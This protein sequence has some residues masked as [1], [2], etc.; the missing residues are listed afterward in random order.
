MPSQPDK[1][2]P[3]GG[4]DNKDSER[5]E[6]RYF[7]GEE[8]FERWRKEFV[9]NQDYE[10]KLAS[11]SKLS[12]DP[13]EFESLLVEEPF[14]ELQLTDHSQLI[15][16]AK[17]KARD[18]YFQPI[19]ARIAA[20]VSLCVILVVFFSPVML[21]ITTALAV[22]AA[23]SLH[24]TKKDREEAIKRAEQEACEEIGRRNEQERL[25]YEENKRQHQ[26]K[27]MAR[28]ALIKQLITGEPKAV[29][30][31][32]D[33]A[34]HQLKLP[35]VVQADIEFFADIP[36][37]KVWLPSKAV[38]P[39]QT[40]EMLP[41]GRLQYQDKDTRVFNKQYFE[42]CSGILLQ[43]MS[44]IFA[45]IPSFQEGYAA[46]IV[47]NELTDDCV[48]TVKVSRE[49]ITNIT[50]ANNAIAAMQALDARYECDTSLALYPVDMLL[51]P[52]W[53]GIDQQQI[54]GL[55]VRIFK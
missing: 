12:Y 31:R 3:L 34:L 48:L 16:K 23:V 46:G 54:K 20:I 49:K 15:T 6:V 45:N 47:K 13:V 1:K 50:R 22:A 9:Q 36:V 44:T 41:S 7:R 2:I 38:I 51:P 17:V 19:A 30:A 4:R 37:V 35:V 21:L 33:E 11:V 5:A 14:P 32:L 8:Q 43:L 52:E 42:L 29:R 53:E 40:C 10:L 39:K 26:E 24:F 18:S 27:E 55:Q 28:M 25:A